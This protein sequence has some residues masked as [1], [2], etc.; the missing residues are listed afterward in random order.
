MAD[1]T[2]MFSSFHHTFHVSYLNDTSLLQKQMKIYLSCAH[3]PSNC[4][5][6]QQLAY[7]SYTGDE[8][9][10]IKTTVSEWL[11]VALSSWNVL[12]QY[13]NI[14]FYS[15]T[16]GRDYVYRL[17]WLRWVSFWNNLG[18]RVLHIP[19][20]LFHFQ[21]IFAS[22][23][24]GTQRQIIEYGHYLPEREPCNPVEVEDVSEER[25]AIIIW[26]EKQVNQVSLWLLAFITLR[27]WRWRQY[28]YPKHH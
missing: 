24:V 11:P 20:C 1:I 26:I 22:L 13:V 10:R 9:M 16:E 2:L 17:T 25:T 3:H 5:Y 15:L 6:P 8:G 18:F 19:N 7:M 27:P 4:T 23:Y 28:V 12:Q 21:N 14:L